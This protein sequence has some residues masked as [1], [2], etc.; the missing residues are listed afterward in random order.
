MSKKKKKLKA[1][2]P[3][4]AFSYGPLSVA[5]FGKN[6]VMQSNWPEG[7]FEKTQQKLVEQY[8]GIVQE[9]DQLVTEIAQ[10]VQKL[11]G[12]KLL[13]RAW[14]EMAGKHAKIESESDVGTEEAISMRMVDYIQ[15][16]IAAVQPT[17]NQGT[18][19]TDEEWQTLRT[20]VKELF[21]TINTNYQICLTA[22]H[23][24]DDP[25]LNM[26][27]EEFRF[28][29]QSYWCNI[30]GN[31]YQV[32]EPI[33]LKDMFLP[34]SAVLQE[35]F[36]I[37]AEQFVEAIA[38]IWRNLTFGLGDALKAFDQFRADLSDALDAKIATQSPSSTTELSELTAEVIKEKG[39]E[40]RKADIFGRVLG[41]DLFDMQKTTTLPQQLLDELTWSPGQEQEFF[42]EGEFRGWPLRIWPVFKRPFI[43]LNGRYCCF[44]LY[45]LFDHL[46]RVMQH[47]VVRL[48]PAYQETWKL[49]QQKQSENLPIEYLKRIFPSASVWQGV[50]YQWPAGSGKKEWCE[51]DGLLAYDDH[52]FIIECRG[53]AFTYTSPANDFPAYVASL[54]NL[55]LK[56]ATQG[57]RFFDYLN[58]A[59]SISIFDEHHQQVGELH[60]GAFRHVTI[61]PITL[62]PFTELAAQVQ[63]LR[64]IGVDVGSHPVWAISLDDLRVYADVFENPLIFLHFVEQRMRAFQSD[65]I[66]SDDELDHLGLYLKHNHYSVHAEELRGTSD[67]KLQFTG[68]RSEIDKFFFAR[69]GDPAAPCP[70]KQEIPHR[71]LEIIEFLAKSN[72][73]GRARVASFLL[74]IDG[75]WREQLSNG[76]DH[77]LAQ[78]PT[79]RRPKPLSTHGGVNLTLYCWTSSSLPRNAEQALAHARTVLLVNGE[80]GRLLIELSY[81]DSGSLQGVSWQWVDKA[82]IPP[83]LL[84]ELQADAEKLRQ[85][86]VESVK[87]E[88]G[89][90]GRNESCPCG[91]GKKYKKCCL[92]KQSN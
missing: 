30:R 88:R 17:A 20:N 39:W 5:R 27:F 38:K 19:L 87:A 83:P 61:C 15:S 86:R 41:M 40:V 7:T 54:K 23:K 50:Y 10:L 44:D 79:T 66:Q 45:S 8:P 56:P 48:K 60:R 67:A 91:S 36:G 49:I 76:I 77:E 89:K 58:S 78:Q 18:E 59:G 2:H 3:D 65:I 51:A 71:L 25:N 53:G 24:A 84:L 42:A 80:P 14:W 62:D 90:I 32:H 28:K 37:T 72:Q 35:L 74:D 55:V 82:G 81:A 16:V 33:Y 57:K 64:K 92:R 52:L 85:T 22:K 9:I 26:D 31:R 13:H 4:E 29:A 21:Q 6:V 12:E 43:L 70:L 73:S 63:H 34:H 11:S 75:D 46:Y 68:Y 69:L 47:I 1:V